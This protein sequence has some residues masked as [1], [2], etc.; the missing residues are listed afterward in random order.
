MPSVVRKF[1]FSICVIGVRLL[2]EDIEY[3]GLVSSRM[4]GPGIGECDGCTALSSINLPEG[5]CPLYAQ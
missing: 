1:M 2:L 5:S 4:F 3:W